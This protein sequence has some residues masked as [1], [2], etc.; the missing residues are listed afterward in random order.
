[1]L[2]LENIQTAEMIFDSSKS[3]IYIVADCLYQFEIK[4]KVLT[5]ISDY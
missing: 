2:C 1:M 4:I 3:L 5:K